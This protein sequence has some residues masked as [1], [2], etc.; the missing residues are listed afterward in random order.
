MAQPKQRR[1]RVRG[2]QRDDIDLDLLVQ[3]LLMIGEERCREQEHGATE[4]GSSI[5]SGVE[6]ERAA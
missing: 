2:R 1:I 3:A 4:G 6:G 5:A